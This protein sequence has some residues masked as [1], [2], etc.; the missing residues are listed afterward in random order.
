MIAYRVFI[1]AEV[2]EFLRGCRK[3]DQR[4]ITQLMDELGKNPFRKE[5]YVESDEIGRPIQVIII[6]R[7]ALYYW[8]DHAV[9][10]I[11]VVD[12]KLAGN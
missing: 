8:S 9:K 4:E 1:A 7:Y 10:E 3:R 2:I 5:D 11:K 6:G 12:L